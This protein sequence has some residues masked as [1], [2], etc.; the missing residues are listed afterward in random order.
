MLVYINPYRT[1]FTTDAANHIGAQ[2]KEAA[3]KFFNEHPVGEYPATQEGREYIL[4]LA[5]EYDRK[6]KG[7]SR[8]N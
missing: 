1:I 7:A 2:V 4:R 6:S 8:G 3:R 5:D